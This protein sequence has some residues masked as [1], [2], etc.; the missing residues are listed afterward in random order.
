MIINLFEAILQ[1]QD[2][3][4]LFCCRFLIFGFF[5]L[6]QLSINYILWCIKIEYPCFS[7]SLFFLLKFIIDFYLC[8]REVH[9]IYL[10]FKG[11]NDLYFCVENISRFGCL[12]YLCFMKWSPV[13]FKYYNYY[14]KENPQH[15]LLNVFHTRYRKQHLGTH[16]SLN[17]FLIYKLVWWNLHCA[18]LTFCRQYW[19]WSNWRFIWG[20][21]LSF[22]KHIS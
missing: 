2:Y 17:F 8:F 15:F 1:H 16:Q 11:L 12:P 3:K 20:W 19:L 14:S 5:S 6:C 13:C 7:H 22:E 9:R 10:V 21:L 18:F 4:I